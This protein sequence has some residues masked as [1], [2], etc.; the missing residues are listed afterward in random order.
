MK[1]IFFALCLL[2]LMTVGANASVVLL[3]TFNPPGS[4]EASATSWA[5]T[6]TN[7]SVPE[8][9]AVKFV[10]ASAVTIDSILAAIQGTGDVTLG[11]MSDTGGSPGKPSD[12]FLYSVLLTDP[13]ENVS[14]PSLGWSLSAGTYW[15][16]AVPAEADF[17]GYWQSD[18]ITSDWAYNKYNQ[19]GWYDVATQYPGG[20]GQSPAV[21][22]NAVPEP[23]TMLLLG[24]GLAGLIG[25]GR[26]RLKK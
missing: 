18:G 2:A 14:L 7:Y 8:E 21:R 12:T 15:L 5:L 6:G 3:D 17:N 9:L 1:K 4:N 26:R 11:I 20:L 16:A 13:T 22:I 10:A 19:F 24:S 25:Y 23:S